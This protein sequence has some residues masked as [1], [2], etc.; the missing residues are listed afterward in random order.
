[1]IPGWH[2][3]LSLGKVPFTKQTDMSGTGLQTSGVSSYLFL[4]S[5]YFIFH[6]TDEEANMQKISYFSKFT[7]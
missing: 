6:F 1:M 5:N 4:K 2:F 3:F 7:K